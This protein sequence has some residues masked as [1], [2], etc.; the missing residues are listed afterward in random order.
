MLETWSLVRQFTQICTYRKYTFQYQGP[1]NFADASIFFATLVPRAIFKNSPSSYS[2]KMRWG[3]GCFFAK[4]QHFLAKMIPLLKEIVWELCK[5]YFSSV[6]SFCKIKGYCWWKCK[7]YR[8][9][10]GI[11]LLDYSKLANNQKNNNDVK[12]CWHDVITKIF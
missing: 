3:R 11:R 6:F 8:Y 7:F 5:R 9:A 12:I 1:L 10:F 2:E 4:N